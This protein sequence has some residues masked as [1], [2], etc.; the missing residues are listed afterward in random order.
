M[1]PAEVS[2]IIQGLLA[3]LGFIGGGA[4]LK[5]E[6]KEQVH[7]LTTAAGILVA[8]AIGIA[9][10]LGCLVSATLAAVATFVILSQLH[11]VEDRVSGKGHKRARARR[12]VEER[13]PAGAAGGSA[14]HH[15]R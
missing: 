6:R 10:G 7:G 1:G 15:E 2:R 9:A 8:A 4:I 11:H 12:A 5:L 14:N 13:A 3:G